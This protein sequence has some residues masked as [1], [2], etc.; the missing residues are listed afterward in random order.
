MCF[1]RAVVAHACNP[2][3]LGGRGKRISEFEASLVYRVS[4]RTVRTTQRN[5][6]LE[7]KKEK[8]M[9]FHVQGNSSNIC[10]PLYMYNNPKYVVIKIINC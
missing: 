10:K 2:S 7:K 4:S 8:E 5:P 1:R 6:V 3:T 9:C